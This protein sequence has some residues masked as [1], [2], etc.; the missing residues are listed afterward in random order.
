MKAKST[1]IRNETR[2]AWTERERRT[3]K[4]RASKIQ[5]PLSQVVQNGFRLPRSRPEINEKLAG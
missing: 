3:R 2:S 4:C 1:E 5:A